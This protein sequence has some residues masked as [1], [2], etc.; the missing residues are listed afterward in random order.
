LSS[1]HHGPG[2]LRH[3]AEALHGRLGGHGIINVT[4]TGKVLPCHA[5]ETIPGLVFENVRDT[6]LDQ[7]WL[8]GQ[9]FQKFRGTDWMTSRA[10]AASAA[11]STRVAAAAVRSRWPRCRRRRSGV[12]QSLPGTRSWSRSQSRRPV[13][14]RRNSFTGGRTSLGCWHPQKPLIGRKAGTIEGFNYSEANKNSGV[15]WDEATF[16]EYIKNPKA[17][18]PNTKMVLAGLSDDQDIDDLLAC[19][20]QFGAD[21]KRK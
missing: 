19:I 11:R 14:H 4:P 3:L 1:P 17:K 18:I 2:L 10:A 7:I 9:A 16:R 21:G 6:P 20:K 13:R 15:T 8:Y 5:A 12:R